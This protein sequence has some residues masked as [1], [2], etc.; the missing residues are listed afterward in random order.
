MGMLGPSL[1]TESNDSMIAGKFGGELNLV[2]WQSS[3]TNAVFKFAEISYSHNI[4]I[5]IYGDILFT[6]K[7]KSI[8]FLQCTF[9]TQSP[10]LIPA[11]ISSYIVA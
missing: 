6:A 2:L 4:Y 8:N 7:S 9:G 5:Y 10:N 11:N 1:L 3:F